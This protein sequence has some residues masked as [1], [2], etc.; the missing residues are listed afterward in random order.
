MKY[1][2]FLLCVCSLIL[3]GC[4][5]KGIEFDQQYIRGRVFLTD[6]TTDFIKNVPVKNKQVYLSK[7]DPL[8]YLYS[9]K[10]DQE[11]YFTFNLLSDENSNYTIYCY[12]TSSTTKFYYKA[13]TTANRGDKSVVLHLYLNPD[14]QN[15]VVLYAK[16]PQNAA[17]P[18]VNFRIYNN[19]TLAESNASQGFV[20]KKS[21]SSG[22]AYHLNLPAGDYWI[23]AERIIDTF[24]YQRIAKKITV[25]ATGFTLD[26]MVL[27][28]KNTVN[29]LGIT[30]VDA[31]NAPVAGATV[32]IYSNLAMAQVNDQ[33]SVVATLVSG[34]DGKINRLNTGAGTFYLNAFKLS[35][36]DTLK[37]MVKVVMVQATGLLTDTMLLYKTSA[38]FNGLRIRTMD[39]LN[40]I[41]PG[42]TL[43]LYNNES[44]ARINSPNGI[45][46]I[47]TFTS[48][49]FGY[50]SITNLAE[51][52]YFINARRQIDTLL[53]QRVAKRIFVGPTGIVS[54]TIQLMR[55]VP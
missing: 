14:N 45:G 28:K 21:D 9:V 1:L 22:K 46:S 38:P 23:N 50:G 27:F 24:T 10:T 13:Q 25:G 49:N 2:L 48:D 16:D 30:L 55:R 51:G 43:F 29:G 41:I 19:Q 36:G 18:S 40:G 8:N 34:S 37:R 53:Y 39:S 5:K 26:T 7:G 11:G 12:D 54:D 47:G 35:G 33:A 20:L 15:G 17:L 4:T 42:A 3:T 6:T 32:N 44:F 31:T 52:N